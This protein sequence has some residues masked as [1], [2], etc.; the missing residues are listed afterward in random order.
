MFKQTIFTCHNIIAFH[1]ILIE[2]MVKSSSKRKNAT[3]A[4]LC[5]LAKAGTTGKK[6]SAYSKNIAATI[7]NKR[8]KSQESS[9][10]VTNLAAATHD[11]DNDPIFDQDVDVV[12][13][14]VPNHSFLSLEELQ[15]YIF[16]DDLDDDNH[17]D[18]HF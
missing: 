9:F 7:S 13:A 17:N 1:S 10:N 11:N 12:L 14:G 15:G 8:K 3:Q 6:R 2:R 16:D 4:R 18:D 5:T